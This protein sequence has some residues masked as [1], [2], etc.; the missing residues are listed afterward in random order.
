M[1]TRL[2]YFLLAV[3][4]F[5]AGALL[6]IGIQVREKRRGDYLELTHRVTSGRASRGD[7]E[8]LLTYIPERAE[9]P[10]IRSLFGL[11]L[12]RVD[13]T[14]IDEDGKR[15]ALKDESWLY[16]FAPK[17]I[18]PDNPPPLLDDS[19]ALKLSGPQSCF[20]VNFNERGRAAARIANVIHPVSP[21]KP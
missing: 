6:F 8:K 13:G 20:V 18:D 7:Y 11:P 9:K 4:I 16:Y 19:D 10:E 17:M 12:L 5:F 15:S 14:E 1:N 2:L 21:R 3:Q